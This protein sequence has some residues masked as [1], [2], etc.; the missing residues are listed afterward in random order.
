MSNFHSFFKEFK[1]QTFVMMLPF[2]NWKK[3]EE[4]NCLCYPTILAIKRKYIIIIFYS[5]WANFFQSTSDLVIDIKYSWTVKDATP[6]N[7]R[8][9]WCHHVFRWK[10]ITVI[11][12]YPGY[13]IIAYVY[14]SQNTHHKR[15][16]SQAAL[17][18]LQLFHV[19]NRPS[20]DT[21]LSNFW[22]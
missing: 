3:T 20:V 17:G 12:N 14:Q 2:F 7:A 10:K 19:A 16:K 22:Q 4:I 11:I 18:W 6:L 21:Q 13:S 9:S 1:C 8:L 5:Y 15:K